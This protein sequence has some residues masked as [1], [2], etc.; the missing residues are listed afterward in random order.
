MKITR[1]LNKI[2]SKPK[3]FMSAALATLLII[4][5]TAS[6]T[7]A[8]NQATLEGNVTGLNVTT[9]ETQYDDS[10]DLK[11]DEV[12]QIQLWQ[13][14]REAPG[15]TAAANNKVKFVVPS[16]AGK[17]QV[18]TGIS[19]SDNSNTVTD[20]TQINLSLDKA[21][22]KYVAGSAKF[23]YNKG[24]V[25]GVQSCITGM[26]YPAES[27]Y[28]TVSISD[29][30]VTTGVNLD[31]YRGSSLNGCNA[32]HETVIIQVRS[33]ADSVSVNKYVRHLGQ[34]TAD[35][36][37]STDAKPGDELE[38]QI[39]FKNEG[40]TVLNDVMVGDNLP[41]YNAYV[42][43]STKIM[44]SNFPNGVAAGTDNITKGGINTGD[45]A[46][47]AIGYVLIRVKIDPITA[48]ER[49][50]IYEVANVGV[51]RPAG[52]NEFYNTAIV[53]INVECDDEEEVE[54]VYACDSMSATMVSPN[55]YRFTTT[56]SAS[57]GA[58]ITGY[59]FDF[60]D[61]SATE[62][63][64]QNNVEHTFAPGTYNVVGTVI[65]S[66]NGESAVASSANCVANIKV[67]EAKDPIYACENFKLVVVG[68]N[69]AASF[70]PIAL[71]GA[72]FKNATVQFSA[73]G[74][75]KYSSITNNLDSN[76]RVNVNYTYDNN[77]KKVVV[78]AVLNFEV[79]GQVKSIDCM[80]NADFSIPM[81]EVP[82]KEHLPKDS[83][84]CVKTPP[85]VKG[86]TT[87]PNTGAGE[88]AGLMAVVTIAG[89]VAH[90]VF[91]LKRQ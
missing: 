18:V 65:V 80:G 49:C 19:S 53:K 86:V 15:G 64:A 81:C 21:S 56:G 50:G 60:K 90:R 45:Y 9:G 77:A 82:G 57:N 28:A 87:L 88:M 72:V 24:A 79:K 3:T 10:T 89:A 23:R 59:G 63:T 66:V 55:K 44:N 54:P 68:R 36:K 33:V 37:T 11:V 91:T 34:T 4:G 48:F 1:I 25:D 47:G 71:N 52:M 74:T 76:G 32:Y 12:A 35:W 14:N 39:K 69:V 84:L 62:L 2:A 13:H 46:A 83:P 27:C 7:Q 38:Y 31:V 58:T 51:V 41:K 40:N 73:D 8:A 22:L 78:R 6:M 29:D 75:E 61:G 67:E 70:K 20:T 30:V 43:G 26:E 5:L 85:T 42:N 16:A 17:S